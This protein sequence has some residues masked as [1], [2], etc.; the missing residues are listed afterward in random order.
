MVVQLLN[1]S[2]QQ[3]ANLFSV[4]EEVGD[5]YLVQQLGSQHGTSL[6]YSAGVAFIKNM[7]KETQKA[8][9]TINYK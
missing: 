7:F 5:N 3:I 4:V 6:G 9:E 8:Q 1:P 2:N